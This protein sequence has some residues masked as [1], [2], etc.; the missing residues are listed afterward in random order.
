MNHH[1]H[2]QHSQILIR[3]LGRTHTTPFP[4]Q[5]TTRAVKHI[6]LTKRRYVS[7]GVD[8]RPSAGSRTTGTG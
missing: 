8:G 3:H 6:P 4:R 2:K 7:I 1:P 5:T